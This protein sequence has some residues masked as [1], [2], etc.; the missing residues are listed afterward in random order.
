[1]SYLDRPQEDWEM[2]QDA[3]DKR[4]GVLTEAERLSNVEC[5][6]RLELQRTQA[7]LAEA[8]QLLARWLKLYGGSLSSIIGKDTE[9]F[10]RTTDSA[11]PTNPTEVSSGLVPA[12]QPSDALAFCGPFPEQSED[13]RTLRRLLALAYAGPGELYG[14]DG[15][16]QLGGFPYPI[17]F[18]RMS[19]QEIERRINAR[20]MAKLVEQL[21]AAD[22]SATSCSPA[23]PSS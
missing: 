2:G 12:D 9:D 11:S 14:D 8:E 22:Q 21:Q 17:D 7:R 10:L 1:M 4:Q 18:R 16:L 13:E 3:E 15:E 19:A 20:G 23:S 6:V 5:D